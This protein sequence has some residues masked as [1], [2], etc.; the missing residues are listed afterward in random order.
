[1]AESSCDGCFE[2]I[3]QHQTQQYCPIDLV[4]SV[5]TRN[6]STTAKLPDTQSRMEVLGE[7]A[8]SKNET[9]FEHWLEG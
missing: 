2:N 6:K 4:T 9:Q 3:L 8:P 5:E 1:L 7:R